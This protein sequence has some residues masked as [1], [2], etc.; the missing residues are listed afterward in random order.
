M[1]I[2]RKA[3]LTALVMVSK[4]HTRTRK[5]EAGTPIPQEVRLQLEGGTLHVRASND[6]LDLDLPVPVDAG[7]LASQAALTTDPLPVIDFLKRA[8]AGDAILDFQPAALRVTIGKITATF[9]SVAGAPPIARPVMT[10]LGQVSGTALLDALGRVRVA[11]LQRAG[12]GQ[13]AFRGVLLEAQGGVMQ[14]IATDGHQLAAQG[15]PW[16][17]D[18]VRLLVRNADLTVLIAALAV[19]GD[20]PLTLHAN[21]NELL[22]DGRILARVRL[23][24]QRAFPDYRSAIPR[25]TP[26]A[27]EVDTTDLKRALI[28]VSAVLG[29][30]SSG[31]VELSAA[32][33]QLTLSAAGQGA[34]GQVTLPDATIHDTGFHA[35]THSRLLHLATLIPG[36]L[37]LGVPERGTTVLVRGGAFL[38]LLTRIVGVQITTPPTTS[39]PVPAPTPGVSV[40][41]DGAAPWEAVVQTRTPI[42]E[43]DWAAIAPWDA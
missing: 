25:G 1:H 16:S 14:V 24:D 26:A 23:M 9:K 18:A 42:V 35:V 6:S 33:G 10:R 17:G 8:E 11:A 2:N 12:G 20:A 29:R 43:R 21:E 34:R 40:P 39:V 41:I 38:G 7:L 5:T 27:V 37:T 31:T 30:D 32:H 22:L 36:Q 4:L 19:Q 13:A 28:S 3:F 15:I